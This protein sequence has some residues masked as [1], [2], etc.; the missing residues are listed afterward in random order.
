MPITEFCERI[1]KELSD[2]P[3][4]FKEMAMCENPQVQH[5]FLIGI[6]NMIEMG[7]EQVASQ[8]ISVSFRQFGN[9]ICS[10]LFRAKSFVF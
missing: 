8:I 10:F 1:L 6:A 3:T 2:W 4:A 5:R 7:G 9:L